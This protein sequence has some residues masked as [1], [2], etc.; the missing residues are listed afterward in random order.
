MKIINQYRGLKRDN[1][2]LFI[3]RIVTNLGAMIWPMM[4]LILNKKLGLNATETATFTIVTG[5]L[6]LPANLLGGRI[7]DH[8]NKKHVIVFCDII[9]IVLFIISGFLPLSL[10]MLGVPLLGAFFQS[11]EGPAYQAMV[12]D[13]TPSEKREKAYSLSYLGG[14]I[15]LILSPTIAG[16]LFNHYLW[17]SF[18]ISGVAIGVSTFLIAMF[19]KNEKIVETPEVEQEASHVEKKD[20]FRIL[21]GSRA[22]LLFVIAFSLYESAYDQFGYLMPL[23]IGRAFPENGS[24]IYGSVTSVNCIIVVLFTPFIT[25]LLEKMS[26]THKYALGCVLQMLSFISFLLSFGHI[27]G[28][29]VSIALFTFGEILTTIMI[30]TYLAERVPENFRGRINGVTYFFGALVTGIV[31]WGTGYVFDSMGVS[32][33]WI[34]SIAI[35]VLSVTMACSVVLADKK[36]YPEDYGVMTP[37]D[38]VSES[39]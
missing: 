33:A 8:F 22:L 25:M 30:G 38:G 29:Y 34:F 3:G 11:L 18:I 27:G 16:I 26:L 15:G 35:T 19:V 23:D 21:R 5:I 14:N 7:A 39:F 13:I 4:T 2:I 12:A 9:S 24:V 28:Y 36:E 1:Y 6:F 31:K 10:Y 20:I 37:R 17:L 32:A